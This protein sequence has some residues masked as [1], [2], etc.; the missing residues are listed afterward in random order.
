MKTTSTTSPY[1]IQRSQKGEDISKNR[2]LRRNEK[3]VLCLLA[4][5]ILD[6]IKHQIENLNYSHKTEFLVNDN[7]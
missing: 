7:D 6:K 2:K 1:Q 4:Q 5:L 3:S